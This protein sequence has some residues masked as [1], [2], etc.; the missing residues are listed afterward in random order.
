M[1]LLQSDAPHTL[2]ELRQQLERFDS[3]YHPGPPEGLILRRDNEHWCLARAKLVRSGFTQAIAEHWRERPLEWNG[4]DY[5]APAP[6][7]R[8][9]PRP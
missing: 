7:P 4:I 5:S 1:P 8:Q 3:R 2:A 9:T 6:S